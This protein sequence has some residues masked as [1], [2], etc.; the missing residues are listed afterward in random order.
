VPKEVAN[1]LRQAGFS[2]EMEGDGVLAVR[3]SSGTQ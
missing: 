2:T 1:R 3:R